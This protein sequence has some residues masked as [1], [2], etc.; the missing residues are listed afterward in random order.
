MGKKRI[1]LISPP[2]PGLKD[3]LSYPPLGLLYLASNLKGNH[4]VEVLNMV[5]LSEMSLIKAGYA[6]YGVSI[7]SASTYEVARQIIE[8]IRNIDSDALIVTG[9][10][11]PTSMPEFTLNTTHA[12][13]VVRG[14]GETIFSN[15]CAI[16][17][18]ESLKEVRGISFKMNG[19][20]VHNPPERLIED[21]DTIEFPAR[22]LLPRDMVRH[23]G[24]V[25]HSDEPATTIFATRGC[26]W[27]CS[28]CDKNVWTRKWRCRSP[29]NI[30][31]EI[32]LVKKQYDIHWFRFPD[33]NLTVNKKYFITLCQQLECCEVK[34][35]F[36]SRSDTLDI[37]MLEAAKRA[38]CVEI[39]F[40]FESGSQELL[41]KMNKKVTVEQNVKAIE[42]CR[43]VGIISCAYMMFGFPGEN[44][45]TLQETKEFLLRARPD[46]SRISTFI[47]IPGTD[48]WENPSKYGVR[49][50][51][52]FSDFWY[53]DD[54]QSGR[55]CS[56][57]LEYDYLPGGNEKMELL[58]EEILNFYKEQGYLEG[59][60]KPA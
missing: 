8:K 5:N 12:G 50:K 33:D 47:P 10:S 9:G 21:L 53:F 60:A 44:E 3:K 18:T 30:V 19:K 7:H 14:E 15:L 38:G 49:I 4:T 31:A 25:H 51:L 52:N 36:L 20:V 59:W 46:K 41:D 39:F 24:G 56:F 48:V 35:T 16:E 6:L 43:E 57:G 32:E 26:P 11:F 17:G 42:M 58:R 13:V 2:A 55:L 22:H 37:E 34:W 27:R 54:P 28:Y 23:E 40:G 1:L 29:E 45:Q